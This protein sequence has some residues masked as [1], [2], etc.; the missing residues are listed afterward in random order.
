M[1]PIPAGQ[2]SLGALI[3]TMA[4]A[5]FHKSTLGWKAETLQEAKSS[6]VTVFL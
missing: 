5:N 3:V 2:P 1:P 4:D 6:V